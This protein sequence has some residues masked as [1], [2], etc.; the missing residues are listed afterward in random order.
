MTPSRLRILPLVLA[1]GAALAVAACN[2]P[3]SAGATAGVGLSDAGYG[4]GNPNAKVTV[5][6]FAS[7]TCPH[8]AKWEEEVWPAFKAKYVD[9]G[10]VHYLFHEF[11]IHEQQDAAGAL[12]ARCVSPD[13]YFSTVQAIFRVQPQIFAGDTRG[14]LLNVAQSQG[15]SEQQFQT[16]LSDTKALAAIGQRQQKAIDQYHVEQ[17][18]TFIINGKPVTYEGELFSIDKMSAVIDPLLK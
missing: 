2:K 9:T 16:C 7:L 17:T 1:L 15:M 5:E 12:L 6:E 8:C 11:L 14:A 13:K 10:K 4:M 3:G 18:P